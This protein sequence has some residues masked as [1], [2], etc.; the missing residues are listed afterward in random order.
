MANHILDKG[1]CQK[2][3]SNSHQWD[4]CAKSEHDS[5]FIP[6]CVVNDHGLAEKIPAI[7]PH[8][9]REYIKK[10]LPKMAK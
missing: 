9:G 2:F 7:S 4:N 3:G 8:S 6:R 1:T 5:R 10:P